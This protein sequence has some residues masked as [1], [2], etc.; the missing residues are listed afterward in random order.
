[1]ITAGSIGHPGS[2]DAGLC[3]CKPLDLLSFKEHLAHKRSPMPEELE[4]KSLLGSRAIDFWCLG[5]A[6]IV[7]W[8]ALSLLAPWRSQFWAIDRHFQNLPAFAASAVLLVN[9]PHFMVSYKLSYGQGLKFVSRHWWQLIVVPILLV[10]LMSLAWAFYQDPSRQLDFLSHYS[11]SR[12]PAFGEKLLGWLVVTMYFTVGWHYAKQM[13]G[14]MMVYARF[15]QYPISISQRFICKS[16]LFGVWFV[17]YTAFTAS[18]ATRDFNGVHFVDLN[19]PTWLLQSFLF[20][21]GASLFAFSF[22]VIYVNYRSHQKKPSMNFLLPVITFSI[23]WIPLFV[24]NDFY[25]QLVPFFHS[26]QYLCFVRKSE[27]LAWNTEK[28]SERSDYYLRFAGYII[29]LIMS[30]WLFFEMI[31]AYL[32]GGR[33]GLGISNTAFF[34]VCLNVFINIHHYFIDNVIWRFKDSKVAQRLVA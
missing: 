6:S 8:I 1:M 34:Y 23:W 3:C 13:F 15:D 29:T 27:A 17:N 16:V 25:W 14:V 24:Q 19:A 18:G 9:Y 20:F 5:G 32:D 7:V 4:P 30:G 26:L 22:F 2:V 28:K 31:P 10:S 12:G 33:S 11:W 21:Y